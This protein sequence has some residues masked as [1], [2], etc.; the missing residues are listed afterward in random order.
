MLCSSCSMPSWQAT[1]DIVSHKH[2]EL[3]EFG[4]GEDEDDKIW[5]PVIRQALIAGYIKKDVENYGL[6]K[7]TAAGKRFMKHP[8]SFMIVE[9]KEFK[10]EDEEDSHD[11]AA[12][13]LDP[14]LYSILKDLRKKMAKKLQIPPYVIFQDVSLEQMATMYPVSLQELQNIQG[15]G[16]GK[17]KRYG[18][19]FCDRKTRRTARSH[20]GKEVDAKSENHPEYRPSGG[21]R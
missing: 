5:N 9:D 20:S 15:V 19:E 14:E 18:Q 1:D 3:D 4:S 8:T 16:A 11:G 13:A 6:L 21:S 2:D 7:I 10:D 17:A 12:G